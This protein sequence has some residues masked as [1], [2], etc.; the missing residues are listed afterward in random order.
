[1]IL[2]IEGP[3]CSGKTSLFEALKPLMPTARF[4]PGGGHCVMT[5]DIE[6]RQMQIFAAMYDP[7]QTYVCDRFNFVSAPVYAKL[8]GREL[9]DTSNWRD[10][11]LVVYLD[12]PIHVL[13]AR[14]E[15][16]GESFDQARY[17]DVIRLYHEVLRG[18]DHVVLDGI[19]P[20]GMLASQTLRWFDGQ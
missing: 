15:A 3:D 13:C 5:R 8:Y 12:V 2:V 10:Q 20:V 18:F 7:F 19:L 16:R 17:E 14:N 1:M 4:I 11:V 6:L 9:L